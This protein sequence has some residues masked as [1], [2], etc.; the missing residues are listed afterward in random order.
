MEYALDQRVGLAVHIN[1]ENLVAREGRRDGD[2]VE[3]VVEVE[4]HKVGLLCL[5]NPG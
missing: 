4:L 3:D 1:V 2:I 5:R